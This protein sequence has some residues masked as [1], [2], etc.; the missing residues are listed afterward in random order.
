V[1]ILA[2]V[3]PTQVQN[4]APWQLDRIDQNSPPLDGAYHFA[5][6]GA[7]VDL[8]IIDTGIRTTHGDFGG[9]T[10]AL[11]LVDPGGSGAD[12]HG[13]GTH[14]ASLAAGQ[15]SGVAREASIVSVRA[16]RC[17]GYGDVALLVSALDTV[18]KLVIAGKRRAVLNM[19]IGAAPD[20]AINAGVAA[21][22]RDADV[23]VIAAAGNEATNACGTRS[24]AGHPD[25]ITVG[26]VT[27]VDRR[28]FDSNFGACVTIYAP[29]DGDLGADARG[30]SLLRLMS[31]TSMAAP[32]VAGV[33][34]QLLEEDP[35]AHAPEIRR[36]LF[37]RATQNQMQPD[38]QAK[39][40]RLLFA[41]AP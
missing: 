17:D 37:D 25:V 33:A 38:P 40:A 19:S 9:R 36:R 28:R 39:G 13:H 41:G 14:V 1:S 35:N 4:H 31:G 10:R 27:R 12:C 18:A 5:R 15:W 21:L 11:D 23:V 22:V 3:R 2:D 6:T 26:A 20:Q 8:Y 34:A 29:G 30:D 7:G 16:V 32:L 24:P